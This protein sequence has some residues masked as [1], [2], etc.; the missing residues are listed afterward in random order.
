MIFLSTKTPQKIYMGSEYLQ[1]EQRNFLS[2]K[3]TFTTVQLNRPSI[4][5]EI[6]VGCIKKIYA[7]K[8]MSFWFIILFQFVKN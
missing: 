2:N 8:Y 7:R 5:F 4:E 1:Y 6:N 3:P